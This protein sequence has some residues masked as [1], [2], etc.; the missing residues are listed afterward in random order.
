MAEALWHRLKVPGL[1]WRSRIVSEST[2]ALKRQTLPFRR[3]LLREERPTPR[4]VLGRE[5]WGKAWARAW[6][7][8]LFARGRR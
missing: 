7:G 4:E 2:P 1:G 6:V 3:S 8:G 5:P